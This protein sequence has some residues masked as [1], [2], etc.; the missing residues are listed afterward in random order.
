[1]RFITLSNININVKHIVTIEYSSKAGECF[2]RI[3]CTN[4][5]LIKRKFDDEKSVVDC[6]YSI[7]DY[8]ENTKG[9]KK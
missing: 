6:Y 2:I 9:K 8:L 3:N 1:M 7:L 4:G 5:V